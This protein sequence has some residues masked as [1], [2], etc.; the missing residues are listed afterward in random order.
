VKIEGSSVLV[1]GASSGIGAALAELLAQRGATVGLVARREQRL[2]EVVERCQRHTPASRYWVADLADLA[3][4]EDVARE[5][6]DAFGAVD[7]LVNNA[8]IPRRTPVTRLT[9]DAI[10]HVMDVNFHAPVRMTLALLSRWLARGSGCVVNVAS[11]G[12][13]IPI[14]HEAAY[15][16]SKFALAGWTETMAV[17]LAG[18]GIEVKLALPGPIDTEIW[19]QPDNDPAA[20]TGPFVPADECA[21]AIVRALEHDGFEYYVPAEMPGGF[22]LQHDVVVMKTA[23]TDAFIAMMGASVEQGTSDTS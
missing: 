16:A 10:A 1:T 11:L 9:P 3:R 22:G 17:D 13:R 4:A 18:T 8:G 19:D 6:W 5:A 20:F 14:A 15:C 7:G 21:G 2:R 12:A 23:D